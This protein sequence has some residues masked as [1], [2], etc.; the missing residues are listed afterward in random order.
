[1]EI[2]GKMNSR[3]NERG[4]TMVEKKDRCEQIAF[5]VTIEE[6]NKIVDAARRE[7]MSVS[8][9]CRRVILKQGEAE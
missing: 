2:F 7:D 4:E 3:L 6:K 1:M 9:Y 8:M 5:S